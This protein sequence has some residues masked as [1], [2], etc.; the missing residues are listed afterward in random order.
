V[1]SELQSLN[2]G[3]AYAAMANLDDAIRVL[4]E[5]LNTAPDSLAIANELAVVLM[6]RGRDEEAHAVFDLA[7]AKHP[8]DLPT[9]I[10]YLN[11][12]VTS[13]SEKAPALA[14]KLI[15]AYPD[16]WEV[17]YLNS[18][19]EAREGDFETARSHLLRSVALHPGSYQAH[20]QLGNILARLGDLPGARQHLEKAIALGDNAPDVEYSLAKVLQRLGDTTQAQEKLRIY[21]QLNKA[22]LNTTQAAG[23]A[24]EGDQANAAGDTAQ[25]AALY[26]EALAADPDEPLLLYKLAKALDKLKDIDGEKTAL[27]RAIQLN[28]NLAEAQNQ[29]G[30]LAVRDGDAAQAEVYFQ[31]AVSASPSYV[32]AWINLAAT[33]ASEEKWKESRQAIGRA[34]E[35]DPDNADARK[36]SQELAEG[37][38]GP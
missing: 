13:H 5:G 11:T 19:L 12:L 33:F 16:H 30:Y 2:L 10:L 28:P 35:A 20:E 15:A 31:A 3:L 9:Q 7:L 24:E 32:G 27:L 1:R 34:L 21:E 37:H 23:K 29:L 22:R 8:D 36:L 6:L 25:A 18:V 4:R 17:L 14:R 38:P 26:R